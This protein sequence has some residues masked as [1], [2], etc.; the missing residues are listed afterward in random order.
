MKNPFINKQHLKDYLIYGGMA[1]LFYLVF[2]FY[3][4]KDDDYKSSYL[5]YI[6]NV[7]FSIPILLYNLKLLKQPYQKERAVAM[8]GSAHIATAVGTL[9]SV[10]LGALLMLSFHPNIFSTAPST[11]ALTNAPSN[12]S[13][14]RP[15]GW[16]FMVC[17]NAL[18][19]NFSVAS[20]VSLMITYVGKR[21]QTKDKPVDVSKYGEN[22]RGTD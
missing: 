18:L 6:G 21:D 4:L 22:R 10:V 5:L 9:L 8:S 11:D 1:A 13:M 20:F 15:A 12:A 16:L 3:H 14:D 19:I 7:A 2:L 17:I